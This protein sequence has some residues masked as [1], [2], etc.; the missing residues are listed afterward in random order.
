MYPLAPVSRMSDV[1]GFAAGFTV[2]VL[3]TMISDLFISD[4]LA[5][6]RSSEWSGNAALRQSFPLFLLHALLDQIVRRQVLL[7]AWLR[8]QCLLDGGHC[9]DILLRTHRD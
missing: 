4:L 6:H 3:T 2:N 8:S 7:V 1:P 9:I 5:R